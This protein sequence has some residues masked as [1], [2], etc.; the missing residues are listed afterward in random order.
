MNIEEDELRKRLT[1]LA[2]RDHGY[3]PVKVK[4]APP[5]VP[6]SEHQLARLR[7]GLPE[8]TVVN[9]GFDNVEEE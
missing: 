2:E 1:S 6:P 4:E 5:P 7:E 8:P 3:P 9:Q